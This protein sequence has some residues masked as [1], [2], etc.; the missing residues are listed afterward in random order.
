MRVIVIDHGNGESTL[1]AHMS[2]INCSVGQYVK[3]GDV[4]GYVGSTGSAA[5]DQLHFE[6]RLN[7]EACNPL[8]VVT[9]Y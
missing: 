7:G 9:P 4:I 2:S 5:E 8:N 1:Y 3:Q 6:V